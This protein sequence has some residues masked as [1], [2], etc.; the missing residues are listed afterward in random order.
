MAKPTGLEPAKEDI[1]VA[2]AKLNYGIDDVSKQIKNV[3]RFLLWKLF[4]V[5]ESIQVTA[6]HEDLLEQAAGVGEFS[7]SL[8][9]VREGL[10]SLD[11]SVEKCV[12]IPV[13]IQCVPLSIFQASPKI[14]LPLPIYASGREALAA[15]P[16]SL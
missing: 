5:N 1:S 11:V 10:D 8:Q 7:G 3:V 4:A 12:F 16:A 6:H 9:A 14:P 15:P 2:I 13:Y